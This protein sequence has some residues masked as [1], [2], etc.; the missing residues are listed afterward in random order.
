[1]AI[2]DESA[3]EKAEPVT[4]LPAYIRSKIHGLLDDL[5]DSYAKAIEVAT[6]QSLGARMEAVLK[7]AVRDD[8]ASAEPVFPAAV[9]RLSQ[10]AGARTTKKRR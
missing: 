4:V 1:M 2:V 9:P 6:V 5:L 3:G 7:G 8:E 10:R